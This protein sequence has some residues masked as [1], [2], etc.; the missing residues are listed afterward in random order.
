MLEDLQV[1]IIGVLERRVGQAV[2]LI[3]QMKDE[4][5]SL[6]KEI[7]QLQEEIQQR[8]NSIRDLE[9]RNQE[10]LQTETNLKKLKEQQKEQTQSVEKE[11]DEL[12]QRVE[13]VIAILDSLPLGPPPIA[14][15]PP[16][17]SSP[18]SEPIQKKS[19]QISLPA[20]KNPLPGNQ[21]EPPSPQPQ[22][23][24]SIKPATH[25]TPDQIT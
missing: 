5:N 10:L 18:A 21:A 22:P 3:N 4:R 16:T 8:D 19:N 20:D 15:L 2:E 7:V 1:N 9:T 25:P 11:K 13:S 14:G 6:Q 12:R 24:D 23:F 17:E